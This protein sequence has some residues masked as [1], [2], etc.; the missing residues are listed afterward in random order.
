LLVF[1]VPKVLPVFREH[2][3]QPALRAPKA[4]PVFREHKVQLVPKAL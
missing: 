3:V 4:L 2:K 1:R